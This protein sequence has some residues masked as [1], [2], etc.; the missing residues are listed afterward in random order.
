MAVT[1][2]LKNFFFF[3]KYVQSLVEAKANLWSLGGHKAQKC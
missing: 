3:A 2:R 1:W